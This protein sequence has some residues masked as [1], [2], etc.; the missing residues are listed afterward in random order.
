MLKQALFLLWCI[1]F[2]AFAGSEGEEL[3]KQFWKDAAAKRI[4]AIDESLTSDFQALSPDGAISRKRELEL[5]K[6][7]PVKRFFL[8]HVR[9]TKT[10]H[11]MVVTYTITI[12]NGSTR[13][14]FHEL[15]IYVKRNGQWKLAALSFIPFTKG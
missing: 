1:P 3:V 5:L 4:H 2:L 6:A 15:Y 7:L 9:T 14:F 12:K 13:S 8:S 10:G 11:R